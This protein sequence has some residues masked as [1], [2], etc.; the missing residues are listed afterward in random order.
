MEHG[1]SPPEDMDWAP[2]PEPGVEIVRIPERDD[3]EWP[4]APS[5]WTC[6]LGSVMFSTAAAR[7]SGR[8][9]S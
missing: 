7:H 2:E 6:P 1:R 3:D 8:R 5:L 9:S 4:A